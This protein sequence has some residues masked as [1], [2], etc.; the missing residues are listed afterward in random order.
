MRPAD[1]LDESQSFSDYL[2]GQR[3]RIDEAL[4]SWTK[5]S[6]ER[7]V[8]AAAYSL[9]LS[10]KRL[11]PLFCLE[12][13]RAFLGHDEAAIPAAMA[14]EMVHTYSLIHDDLPA[15][16]NDDLR[17][18]KPTNHRVYGE[19]TA[20]L[21]GSALLT[22]A[23]EI[24]AKA[25]RVSAETKVAWVWELSEAAGANG[26][27]LGQDWDMRAP[28]EVDLKYL[29]NLHRKKTGA[30]LAAS[31]VMGALAAGAKPEVIEKLRDF[32]LD[33]GL[34]FQIQDDILDVIGGVE[35]GKPIKSDDRNNKTTYVTLLGLENAKNEANLWKDRA[36]QTLSSVEF[37]HPNCLEDLTRFVIDRKT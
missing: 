16:D 21:A 26:M 1:R 35:I 5:S 6:N 2:G 24:L 31:V 25:P 10:S 33:M 14:L 13:C 17:R 12:T 29:Q 37:A 3:K 8:E 28:S 4:G 36:L 23:F 9:M 7:V 34:A 27:V 22:A 32:S 20:L 11:R 30:L 19:A 18:G 15:M